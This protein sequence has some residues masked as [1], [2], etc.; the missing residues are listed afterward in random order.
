MVIF[1]KG[2]DSEWTKSSFSNTHPTVDLLL[3]KINSGFLSATENSRSIT[4][5]KKKTIVGKDI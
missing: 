4:Q 2:A 1:F 5:G 3:R